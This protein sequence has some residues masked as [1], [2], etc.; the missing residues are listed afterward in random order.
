MRRR[1]TGHRQPPRPGLRRAELRYEVVTRTAR[2][3]SQRAIARALRISRKTVKKLL[4]ENAQ[5]RQDGQSAL[6]REVGPARTPGPSKLDP[7][8]D[9]LEAWLAPDQFP[10]LTAVRALEKL[11]EL[12]F[13]GGYTIVRQR[14]N[15]LR[16]RLRPVVE[17]FTVV[18][19]APGVQGQFDWSPYVLQGDLKVQ[20]WSMTLS[21][22]RGRSFRAQ[23]DQKQTTVLRC[24]ADSFEEFGGVPAQGVTDSMPGVVDRWERGQ[25]ILNL[26]FVDFAA[27][28]N[29]SLLVAP[30][31]MGRFKGKVERPFDYVEKNLLNGRHFHSFE[32][33]V[34][35]LD[36][37]TCQ[38]AM[39]RPHPET[40]LPIEQMLQQERPYLQPLPARPYDTRDVLI[41]QVDTQGYVRHAT[42][43]YRVKDG[44]VGQ[45]VYVVA[46]P[47][48][49]QVYSDKLHLIAEHERAPGGA[50]ARVGE[51]ARRSRY[52]L[53]LL[54]ARL[55]AWAP[56]AEQ[57]ALRLRAHKRYPGPELN[58]L[59]GLH[60]SW[61]ADDIVNAIVH[62]MHYEAYD[63]GAV[64]RILE[65][66][67]RP[68]TLSQQIA[69]ATRA[70]I[71]GAMKDR[72]VLQRPLSSYEALRRGDPPAVRPNAP[73][74]PK[75]EAP[76]D[77]THDQTPSR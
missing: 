36:F 67:F 76:D 44:H 30:R 15:E 28:Y 56:E 23:Q 18:S 35:E 49:L 22:S 69:E 75:T 17:E 48:V 58:H 1:R 38:R 32:H 29:L 26:R 9:R 7:Y 3:D 42:N 8:M 12:G 16:A 14:L 20:L 40:K 61:S 10:D 64:E 68:R 46:G 72:P 71:R 50:G 37:W 57:Y 39:K 74:A 13:D 65:A 63:A 70:R 4:C 34:E 77:P 24:L 41:H 31:A 59:L 21:W 54:T 62:A 6:Q 53:E 27:Y 60:L 43:L 45:L 66:R 47:Q 73:D 55:S 25:P 33:F 11:R 5:R 51:P 2:G 52:D 19:T